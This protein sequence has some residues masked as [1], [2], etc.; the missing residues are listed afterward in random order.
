MSH[1]TEK[2]PI[3][4]MNWKRNHETVG[5]DKQSWVQKLSIAI[6]IQGISN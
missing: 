6:T 4:E 5:F 3:I 1:N 2:T